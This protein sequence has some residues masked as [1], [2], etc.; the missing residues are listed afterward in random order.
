MKLFAP[1]A[2]GVRGVVREVLVKDGEMVE[3]DALLMFI[4]PAK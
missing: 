2:A 3:F 1:V 4:E